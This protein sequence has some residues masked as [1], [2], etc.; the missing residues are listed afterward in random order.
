[1]VFLN[2]KQNLKYGILTTKGAEAIPWDRLSVDLIVPYTN[3]REVRDKPIIIKALAIIHVV[4]GW[5]EIVQYNDKQESIIP[6][7]VDQTWLCR[8]QFL[9]II[10]YKR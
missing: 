5:F 4:T 7:I 1:M 6:N 8:Y 2:K 10:T 3:M 9:M